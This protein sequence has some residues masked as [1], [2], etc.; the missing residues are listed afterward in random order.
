MENGAQVAVG[1]V[2]VGVAAALALTGFVVADRSVPLSR[3]AEPASAI[4]SPAVTSQLPQRPSIG[5]D[6]AFA[7]VLPGALT[8]PAL[9]IAAAVTPVTV[10]AGGSLDVP[11]DPKVLG[12]W[13]GGALPGS[14]T[15]T[16]VVDGHVDSAQSGAGSLFK[17]RDL[18][19]GEKVVI[20]G[21]GKSVTYQ[22][23]G[24]QEYHKGALPSANLFT[25]S[26]P[27]RLLLVTCGGPFNTATRHYRDDIVAAAAPIFASS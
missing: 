7:G 22:V 2:V 3:G 17:L 23:T 26:G 15:G 20:S 14:A 4:A 25:R 9:G 18:Q 21:P 6:E 27:P 5:A 13:A 1:G 24:V 16:V 19:I 12:W 11:G 10:S 8:I